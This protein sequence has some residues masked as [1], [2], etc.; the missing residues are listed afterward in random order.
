MRQISYRQALN[1]ALREELARDP[2]IIMLGEDIGPGGVMGVTAGLLAE[3]GSERIIDM[4][5]AETAI[6]GAA[7]GAALAGLRPVAEI[8]HSDFLFICMDSIVNW[9]AKQRFLTGGKV[10][11]PVTIRSPYGARGI[12]PHHAQCIEA[13]LHNIPGLKLVM[14]A[15]PRDAKGLLKT[16]IRD[17]DPVIFFESKYGY[18]LEGEVA[19]EDFSIPFGVAEIK[20]S[21]E[22]VTIIALGSMVPQALA[23]AE[24]LAQAGI[25]CEVLDPRTILPLD[26]NAILSSVTRTSRA[27][28]AHEA[29]RT[30]GVGGEIAALIAEH[31]FHALRAPVIRVGAPFTPVPR[32]PYEQI[33]LPNKDSI[34]DAVQQ[35]LTT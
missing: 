34:K 10:G 12:G 9:M 3:F 25:D 1:E 35:V 8:M 28:I 27:V 18:N 20:R 11:V 7:V 16:A 22:D 32:H 31:A 4:P 30:G 19:Q 17:D 24:E 5:I 13:C 26:R 33:Y 23:A 15:T 14:P 29:P 6:A 21:G 2:D